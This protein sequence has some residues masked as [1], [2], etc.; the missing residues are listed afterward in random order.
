MPPSLLMLVDNT[1]SE[2]L[3]RLSELLTAYSWVIKC[4]GPWNSFA[5]V[6]ARILGRVWEGVCA[7]VHVFTLA[8]LSQVFVQ[9]P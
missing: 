1:V 9:I 4:V 6:C 2:Y 3:F 7:C 5:F 8:A